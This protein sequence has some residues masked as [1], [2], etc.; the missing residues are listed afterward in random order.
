MMANGILFY[1]FEFEWARIPCYRFVN[2]QL[3]IEPFGRNSTPP[4]HHHSVDGCH[5]GP[6]IADQASSPIEL[7][8]NHERVECVHRVFDSCLTHFVVSHLSSKND[9]LM[10]T[11]HL[12]KLLLHLSHLTAIHLVSIWKTLQMSI[13]QELLST[14]VLCLF[15]ITCCGTMFY[16]W[17]IFVVVV[18]LLIRRFVPKRANVT[19]FELLVVLL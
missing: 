3:Q 9:K 18:S 10:L 13:K 5:E 4:P 15:R 16:F 17:F 19:V 8:T 7:A 1:R 12:T 2:V 6:S 14:D 11:I